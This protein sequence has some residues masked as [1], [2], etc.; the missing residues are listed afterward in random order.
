MRVD[1]ALLRIIKYKE[2]FDKVSGYIPKGES[3]NERT[4]R[5]VADVA[6]YF[7]MHKEATQVDMNVFRSLFFTAWH[8]S[9]KGDEANYYNRVL[10]KMEQDA[11]ES[12]TKSIINMLVELEFA[13]DVANIVQ[14]FDQGEDIDVVDCVASV[15]ER[16]KHLRERTTVLDF[17][18]LEDNDIEKDAADGLL[19]HLDCM[20][21]SHRPLLAGDFYILASRPGK[22]K[23]S[24]V[25]H[26]NYALATQL[27]DNKHIY[28]F[29]NES[30]KQRII[31]RQ[32]QSALNLTTPEVR[33]LQQAGKLNE[34]YI[35]VMHSTDRVRVFD[36]HDDSNVDIE[37]KL[38]LAEEGSIGFIIF[39][40]LD[41]VK[42]LTRQ[43]MPKHLQLESLYQWARTLGVKYNCPVLATSQISVEGDELL[44]PTE[45]MLKESKTG[46]QGACDGIIMLGCANNPLLPFERG[47]SMPKTKTEKPGAPLLREPINFDTNR[48][49][50]GV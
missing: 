47:I 20:N 21:E 32:I 12:V 34:E 10:D 40:M 41:N 8:K 42:Y 49:R 27:E 43:D 44:Y 50:Y 30:R 11:S 16:A 25:T 24:F 45:S 38:N 28:W 13:T 3:I 36:V 19:W 4:K 29:N 9:M 22:G 39:D 23:T 14:E 37:D 7:A 26:L 35:K 2:S 46:K 17:A 18:G 15:T 1:L 33:E 48:G 5:V 6:R 31:Q